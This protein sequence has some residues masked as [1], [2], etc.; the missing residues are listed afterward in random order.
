LSVAIRSAA[1]RRGERP[2]SGSVCNALLSAF[3]LRNLHAWN[4][5]PT[6]QLLGKLEGSLENPMNIDVPPEF[7]SFVASLVARRRFLSEK[8]V[9]AESLRLLQAR[10]TL[11]EEVQKGFEQIDA[12]QCGDGKTSFARLR[13]ELVNRSNS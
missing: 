8:E 7:E 12:G 6:T 1:L 3:L 4:Q 11:A 2:T 10:E 13:S 9:V 5:W